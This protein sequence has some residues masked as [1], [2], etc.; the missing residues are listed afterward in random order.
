LERVPEILKHF[1]QS[2]LAAA[3]SGRLLDVASS[4]VENFLPLSEVIERL[5]T[6]PFGSTLHKSDY[7]SNGIP[8]VNPTHINN[9]HITPSSEVTITEKKAKQLQEFR[10][11]RGDVVLAR[12]G[13]MGR[14][15]VVGEKEEGWLCGSGSMLLRPTDQVLSEYL[16]MFL[17]S[18]I[19][20]AN[21]EADS[22]GSTMSNLNQKILLGLTIHVPSIEEQTE[23]VRRVEKL[24]AYAER[25]EA[26]YLSVSERVKQLT[27]SLLAKAFRGELVEQDPSDEPASALLERIRE[28]R[29][30]QPVVS[31]GSIKGRETREYKMEETLEEIIRDL[32]IDTFSFEDLQEKYSGDYEKLKDELFKLLSS[33]NPIITQVFDKSSQSMIFV[34]RK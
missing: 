26:R 8:L 34:R 15:A 16:Q 1:R 6:G 30:A 14:C 28:A 27:P 20:V 4:G 3:T 31:R 29:I 12:R 10:L 13:V 25:L 2:V 21:L 9:G 32:A 22:V 23:I 18:P 7:I 5:K 33:E 17:S 24:F 19:T 11:T